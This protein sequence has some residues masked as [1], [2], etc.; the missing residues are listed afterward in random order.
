M[1]DSS[2]GRG[3][4]YVIDEFGIWAMKIHQKTDIGPVTAVELGRSPLGKP[5]MTTRIYLVDQILFDTGLSHCRKEVLGFVA[6]N[7]VSSV[8][9]TH[10]HE[11]HSGNAAAIKDK[12]SIPVSGH[13][14]TIEK[15]RKP[16]P[17]FPYQHFMWGASQALEVSPLP[18]KIE[19][20]Q[21]TFIPVETPGHSRD[22]TAYWEPNEGWLF[23]GDLYL[24]DRIKYFR[25]DEDLNDQIESLRKVL[26]LEFDALFCAHHPKF[27]KGK[28]HL[29]RKLDFLVSIREAVGHLLAQGKEHRQIIKEIGIEEP[30]LLRFLCWG[31]VR[32]DYIVLSAIEAVTKEKGKLS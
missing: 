8:Y 11:D 13:P 19:S 21:F 9:L 3:K 2:G 30:R 10:H 14:I 4:G 18:E 32:S 23:S 6:E 26:K 22:H 12:F 20:N 5:I 7:R 16:L 15:M 1:T 29:Q 28:Q 25:A 17:I 31:N 24:A 27:K